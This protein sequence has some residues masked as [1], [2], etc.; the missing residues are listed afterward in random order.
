MVTG[1]AL[2]K[3]KE[4]EGYCCVDFS[5]R[6]NVGKRGIARNDEREAPPRVG[7]K[8]NEGVIWYELGWQTDPGR[9]KQLVCWAKCG[10]CVNSMS[11]VGLE[12]VCVWGEGRD[13]KGSKAGSRE[14]ASGAGDA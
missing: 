8:F 11:G 3:W 7:E 4:V 14:C 13:A 9:R 10:G 6:E 5:N 1:F 2:V 12:P